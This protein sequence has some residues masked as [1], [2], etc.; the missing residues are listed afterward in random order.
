MNPFLILSSFSS[1]QFIPTYYVYL[2]CLL[3]CTE[4][5]TVNVK[6]ESIVLCLSQGQCSPIRTG[7]DPSFLVNNNLTSKC[8]ETPLGHG[9]IRLIVKHSV[10][11]MQPC[12]LS[13]AEPSHVCLFCEIFSR[14]YQPVLLFVSLISLFCKNLKTF[15]LTELSCGNGIV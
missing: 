1:C 14:K 10:V 4:A 7:M 3:S 11:G 8:Q 15:L 13:L 9:S 6:Q 5:C 2:R 12:D